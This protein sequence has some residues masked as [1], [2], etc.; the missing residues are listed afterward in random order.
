MEED[1]LFRI[2]FTLYFLGIERLKLEVGRLRYKRFLCLYRKKFV[3][4]K[5]SVY[6]FIKI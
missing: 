4:T 3:D 6:T 5:E 2:P 1:I